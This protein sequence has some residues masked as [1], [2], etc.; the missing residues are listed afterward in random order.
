[1]IRY[2]LEE[3]LILELLNHQPETVI[4]YMPVYENL[5]AG[6][7][8]NFEIAYCNREAERANGFTTGTL[9]GK[10]LVELTRN[11]SNLFKTLFGQIMQVFGTGEKTETTYFHPI[12]HRHFNV[13]RSRVKG[14][15]LSIARDV[16]EQVNDR[17]EKDRQ[18]ALNNS[19]LDSSI[20]GFFAAEAI[21]NEAGAVVDLKIVRIN[22]AFTRMVS[23]TEEQVVGKR[24]LDVFPS[25]AAQ[26]TFRMNVE[27]IETGRPLRKEI[28]YKGET[29]DAW[30]DVSI[31]KLGDGIIVNFTDITESRKQK[32]AI[33][34]F[35]GYLQRVINAS[36]TSIMML[37]PV[38]DT[39]GYP[40]DFRFTLVNQAYASF[41]QLPVSEINGHLA[42]QIFPQPLQPLIFE[43]YRD[44]I[45]TGKENRFH[46]HCVINNEEIWVYV[47]TVKVDNDLLVTFNNYS[48]IK[49]LQQ[50]IEKTAER[51]NAVFQASQAGL[52]SLKPI[53]DEQGNITDFRF[54]IVNPAVASYVGQKPEDLVGDLGSKWFPAYISSGI[55]DM[56]RQTYLTGQTLRK[57]V[58]FTQDNLDLYLDVM[59][60][61]M[62]DE[63]L[64]T[65][66]DFTLLKNL[67]LQLEQKISELQRSNRSLEDFAYAASHDLKEPLRK[68]NF[69]SERLKSQLEAALTEE[70]ARTFQRLETATERMRMLVDDLLAYSQASAKPRLSEKVNLNDVLA[71]V[72]TDLELEITEKQVRVNSNELPVITGNPSQLQQLFQNLV[73]NAIKYSREGV[74]PHVNITA[75]AVGRRAIYEKFAP[76]E[77]RSAYYQIT[78]EDNGIGFEQ[79]NAERIFQVFQRL[80]G[81]AEYKGTGVGLAIA[82]KVAEHH[83]GFIE[84]FGE[85]GKGARF[86]VYLPA[87]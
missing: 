25:G 37:T 29:M 12:F 81:N 61:K 56:Y 46:L 68:I 18:T 24:Y 28:R 50:Q 47:N 2:R 65:L 53:M 63:V 84:A 45:L 58:H 71:Q 77:M 5:Q 54:V 11:D 35:A 83:N 66:N 23:M 69:F 36:Q 86:E 48:D 8:I 13:I 3:D 60:T 16:T 15:V 26:G 21:R 82:R 78:V 31:T 44:T 30:Y 62:E 40:A 22:K 70:T 42:S 64:V 75:K 52:F 74:V 39:S 59:S 80:H 34:T 73:G 32:E 10:T 57:D 19:I 67:Q 55:F 33:E 76:P 79:E 9:T 1:M 49:R 20:N 27:V 38:Y 14:G 4:F 87:D 17:E 7:V 43:N 85:P 6:K 41:K 72:L 51:L